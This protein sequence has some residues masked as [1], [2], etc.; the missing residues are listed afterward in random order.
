VPK[1][2]SIVGYDNVPVAETI[3]PALTT[4]DSHLEDQVKLAVAQL[5]SLNDVPHHSIVVDR[6]MIVRASTTAR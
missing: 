1:D 3:T 2:I 4:I 5:I 6:D